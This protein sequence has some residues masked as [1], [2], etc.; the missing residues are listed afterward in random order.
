MTLDAQ[1]LVPN[2][3]PVILPETFNDPVTTNPLGKFTKP[4]NVLANDA[5]V[6]NEAEMTF[7]AQLLVPKRL[8]VNPAPIA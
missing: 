7:D 3:E 8:P 1:L 6:A 4:S 5:V 2:T